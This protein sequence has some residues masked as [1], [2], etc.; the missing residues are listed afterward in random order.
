M[1][2]TG[3]LL[4]ITLWLVTILSV[5]AI[6]VARYLSTEVRLTKYRL[7]HEQALILA[8]S[9]VYLAI[10]RLVQDEQPKPGGKIYDSLADDW[11]VF[12]KGDPADPTAWVISLAVDPN[13]PA[14]GTR[15]LRIHM[16][17]EE[18]KIDLNQLP[19]DATTFSAVSTLLT[20]DELTARLV[21]SIDGD[22]TPFV[23]P[24][25]RVVGLESDATL[26][27]PYVAKNAHP[28]ALEELLEVPGMTPEAISVLRQSTSV[29]YAT[30]AK[31]NINTVAPEVLVSLGFSP[32]HAL[33]IDA[34]RKQ[35][36]V[37]DDL[38]TILTKADGC[39]GSAGA[40]QANEQ[41]FLMN[42]V[43]ITSQTFTIVSDGIVSLSGGSLKRPPVHARVEAV[44]QR[45]AC[46]ANVP[47]PCVVAW[48]EGRT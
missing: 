14:S 12:P 36:V 48:R 1:H 44:I 47:K 26:V 40:L 33:G 45:Q 5:L 38:T 24:Q 30:Q 2:S 41:T 37:F 21:D 28:V 32:D 25:S 23:V 42:R 8:R 43:G 39:T 27:P 4:I 46:P 16:T 3:S 20:S 22:A 19:S 11:A 31:L 29:S 18:R 6:A 34:C 35:G 13:D 17:D 7:A 15:E 10:Q 9:G